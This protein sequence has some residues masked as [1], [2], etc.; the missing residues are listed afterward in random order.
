MIQ[1]NE[2]DI[3]VVGGGPAGATA[4]ALLSSRG[5]DVTVFEADQHPRFHI[6][7][8]L[9]PMNLPIF[10]QLGVL[11][12]VRQIGVHKPG[13]DFTIADA[14]ATHHSFSFDRALRD[15]PAHAYQVRR[16]ELDALLLENCRAK[17]A[18]VL[19]N[20][21]VARIDLA[22]ASTDSL[23]RVQVESGD[24]MQ[25]G[26][27]CKYLLDASGQQTVLAAQQKW[28][29]RNRDHAS[30]AIF[31][32]F[33]NVAGR[34]GAEQGNISIYWIDAGWLWMIPLKDGRM[35]VGAVCRPDYLKQRR[36]SQEDFLLETIQQ[37]DTAARRMGGATCASETRVAA[38][39]SYYSSRQ[40]GAGYALIGDAYAFIDPVF[41]S[42][43]YLAMSSAASIVPVVEAWLKQQSVRHSIQAWLY[44][45]KMRKGL[46]V[47][48]WFIYRFN[49][50]TM[51]ALF[52]NPR[53]VLKVEQAVTSMLAGDVYRG[54]MVRAR[55]L[56]F[57]FIFNMTLLFG[58]S[59]QAAGRPND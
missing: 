34:E 32:H 47:F 4:G 42:G 48:S 22:T 12:Q 6:G 37:S 52:R 13:A 24:G 19:E 55:L 56:V 14:G 35:S 16:S 50:P 41:S 49:T 27:N 53:N 33:N 57:K 17:G 10:E 23:H 36:G 29:M 44:K 39:Y 21:K 59:T 20:H 5:W 30:A 15:S 45:R 1:D 28:R 54:G 43:V 25:T 2:C 40:I 3:I 11:E 18:T 8:S 58:A 51:N 9:L 31:A 7:E 38:N 26:W 46:A